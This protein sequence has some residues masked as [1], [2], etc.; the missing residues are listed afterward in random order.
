M[1][2]LLVTIHIHRSIYF[3][4]LRYK[5]CYHHHYHNMSV[6]HVMHQH[7]SH[8]LSFRHEASCSR[9]DA[10][11]VRVVLVLPPVCPDTRGVNANPLS[12]IMGLLFQLSL[13]YIP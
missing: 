13:Q 6:F 4:A 8:Q 5:Y 11:V 12:S 3:C 1:N 9:L 7:Q 2:I 10:V